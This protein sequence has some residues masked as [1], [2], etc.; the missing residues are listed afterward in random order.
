MNT[1]SRS[2][3]QYFKNLSGWVNAVL[4]C[5]ITGKV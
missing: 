1:Y 2:T 5:G 3:S 4:I